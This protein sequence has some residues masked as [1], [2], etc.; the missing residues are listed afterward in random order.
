VVPGLLQTA[1]YAR[2]IRTTVIDFYGIPDDVDE[3]RP[4][5]SG[6]SRQLQGSRR[7]RS[8]AR[9]GSDGRE[10]LRRGAPGTGCDAVIRRMFNQG[11][12]RA[13]YIDPSGEVERFEL[14]EP[15]AMVLDPEPARR[16]CRGAEAA[17]A[18]GG[19]VRLGLHKN[20]LVPPVGFEP[21]LAEV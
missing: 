5:S 21:T 11:F 8:D 6:S 17:R 14:T 1:G 4:T 18:V 15:F 7:S 10:H 2:G 20:Y 3:P 16:L 13:L 19:A 12:F 9:Q